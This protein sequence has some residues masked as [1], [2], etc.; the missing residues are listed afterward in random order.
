M[1]EPQ[2]EEERKAALKWRKMKNPA[3]GF[4][5]DSVRK[6]PLDGNP[7]LRDVEET[8]DRDSRLGIGELGAQAGEDFF[9]DKD[10]SGGDPQYKEYL[11]DKRKRERNN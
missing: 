7:D 2:S 10:V 6:S 4:S 3:V 9:I 1:E 8:L 5:A 11:R